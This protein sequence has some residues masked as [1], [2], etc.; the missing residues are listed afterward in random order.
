MSSLRKLSIFLLIG[1][2]YLKF[3]FQ[4]VLK[5]DSVLMDVALYPFLLMAVNY[6]KLR[7]DFFVIFL[8][9]VISVLNSAARNVFLIFLCTY[10]LRDI[11]L[12]KIALMNC[13][14]A[15]II[16]VITFF[17]L[18]AGSLKAE[19]FPQT[20]LDRRV[21]WD[22]GFGNPNTFALFMFSIIINMYIFLA[23]KHKYFLFFF[24][25]SVSYMVYSYTA[26]R[27]FL[28]AI[29]VF[30]I[31]LLLINSGKMF[32]D[33]I[34][35]K[36]LLLGL[37]LL[38]T[39]FI[40][41]IAPKIEEVLFL[42]VVFSGRLSLYNNFLSGLSLK[43]FWIGT[44]AINEETID[45]SY[46]HLLFEGGILCY[47]LFYYLYY[48][49]VKYLNDSSFYILPVVLS[50]L[51]YGLTESVFTFVLIWGNMIIWIVLYQFSLRRTDEKNNICSFSE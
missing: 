48:E 31:V 2:F 40:L 21:R 16:L 35:N 26:S 34:F 22:F 47:A 33:W 38:L 30:Y 36:Y 10:I 1:C 6:R 51:V 13:C 24:T 3:F 18:Q 5:V 43:D 17:M 50:I 8:F 14:Y 23:Q 42:D 27:S 37:P 4:I 41:V 9:V 12:K 29:L 49:T 19:M 25:A 39:G 15:F 28:S 46:L 7:I 32:K 44:S 11:N 45:N 20:L